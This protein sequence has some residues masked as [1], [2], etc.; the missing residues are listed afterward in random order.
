MTKTLHG[1]SLSGE[2]LG[3]PLGGEGTREHSSDPAP[4]SADRRSSQLYS[5]GKPRWQAPDPR[6]RHP[7]RIRSAS[8]H[9]TQ[10]PGGTARRG[11][12]RPQL[13]QSVLKRLLRASVMEQNT[14][15]GQ[16]FI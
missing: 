13:C 7:P 12:G 4:P 11:G 16:T 8:V 9:L 2:D 3:T 5:L 10:D 15:E 14:V 6:S 1:A